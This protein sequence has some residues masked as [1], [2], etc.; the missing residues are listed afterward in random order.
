MKTFGVSSFSKKRINIAKKESERRRYIRISTV[1]P[2]ECYLVDEEGKK[3]TPWLQG[4][5]NNISKGGICLVINDLWLGFWERFREDALVVLNINLPFR[6][7]AI[8][9]RARVIW[10]ERE[11]LANFV[12]CRFG[13]EFVEIQNLEAKT[14]FRYALWKRNTPLV[15]GA[16]VI[17]LFIFSYFVYLSQQALIKE[18]KALVKSYIDTLEKARTLNRALEREKKLIEIFEA[19][20]EELKQRIES[21]ENDLAGWQTKYSELV[22]REDQEA[23]S[24]LK[25]KISDLELKLASLQEE[26][27][28][29]KERLEERRRV[30]AS[31]WADTFRIEDQKR[32]YLPKIVKGMYEWIATRQDLNSGLVLSYEG[33]RDLD[34]VA[35]SYDQ[36]LAS[37][38]FLLFDDKMRAKKILDFYLNQ[39]KRG[40]PIYN[41]YYTNG[42]KFS[43]TIHSGVNAWVGIASLNFVKETGEEQYFKI[44]QAVADFLVR[45]MDEEGGIRGGLNLGWYSTEHNLDSYAFFKM[46]YKLTGEQRYLNLS[47]KIKAWIDR[48]AY[49]D[50]GDVPINR[51]KGDATIATDTY[52]WSITALGPDVLS[53][54]GMNP[55]QIMDFA[56]K[57]C[58]V[59]T[60]FSGNNIEVVG[61]DFSKPRNIPRG[62]VI[63]CEWTAQMILAFQILANFYRESN[64]EK[65]NYYL[66][67]AKFYF[68]E[69]QKMIINSPSPVGKANPTLPYASASFVDTGHGWRTPKGDR[70]GSLASTAYF[71]ISYLGFNPLKGE[72]LNLFLKNIYEG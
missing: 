4:F 53:S 37:I 29:L 69:L 47:E 64:P 34:R 23:A 17:F 5:T 33:D 27:R 36:A 42:E 35:F 26:N 14:L 15:V 61:F 46:F 1:F 63:S 12:Q 24:Q 56:V 70:V 6:K 49:T 44:A 59:K 66:E 25:G 16:I 8:E 48:Y 22:E 18:N 10:R 51:G 65:Y 54:L 11:R 72:Y 43:Y 52:A 60:R 28:L 68:E 31:L 2:V 40:Q 20:R 19:R 57:N 50:R 9:A 32:L 62:G 45:M 38:V 71:L 41:A 30:S 55:E 21:L 67:R 39:I 3:L 13:L 58:Q 7:K